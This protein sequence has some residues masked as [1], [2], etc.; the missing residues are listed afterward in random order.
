MK[1]YFSAILYAIQ[2][3]V[4][5]WAGIELDH[6]AYWIGGSLVAAMMIVECIAVLTF[7]DGQTD[8]ITRKIK[9]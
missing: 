9:Q 1:K 6:K 4:S 2:I 5:V 8:D 7:M 3:P